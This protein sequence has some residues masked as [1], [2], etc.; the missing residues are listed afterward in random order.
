MELLNRPGWFERDAQSK[1]GDLKHAE[2]KYDSKGNKHIS[3][4]TEVGMASVRNW[5]TVLDNEENSTGVANVEVDLPSYIRR[6]NT[7]LG[8]KT[9]YSGSF[10]QHSTP[11]YIS[12][13]GIGFRGGRPRIAS[14]VSSAPGSVTVQTTV[15]DSGQ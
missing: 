14:T 2:I 5:V 1:Q 7:M 13:S 3:A 10:L 8:E 11:M 15:T 9:L 4:Q 6:G 12:N